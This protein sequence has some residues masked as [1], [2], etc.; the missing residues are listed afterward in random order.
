MVAVSLRF[1]SAASMVALLSTV[2]VFAQSQSGLEEII[3]TAQRRE[4]NLQDVPI[5]VT[6][7]SGEYLTEN[8]I[9]S[10]QDLAGAVPGLVVTN[11]LNYGTAPI[12]IRGIGAPNGGG[13]A[14]SDQPVAI[15]VD[16]VYVARLGTSVS[17][18]VDM[19]SIQVLRG[20]QGT[21]YG[22]NSTAG[23]LLL[24]SK[25]PTDQF[26][27]EFR[28]SYA[29]YNQSRLSAA[30]SGPLGSDRILGRLALGYS[31]GGD[32]VDNVLDGRELGGA[33]NKTARGTLRFLPSGGL[34]V[35]LIGEYQEQVAH[36]ALFSVAPLNVVTT[37]TFPFAGPLYEG[38]P[39]ARRADLDSTIEDNRVALDTD[40]FTE[41]RSSNGT[42]LVDWD[43]G[44]ITLAAISGYR[45]MDNNGQQDS[46]AQP[47]TVSYASAN[48]GL[49]LLSN[50]GEQEH[51]QY[52]QELRLQSDQGPLTWVAGAYFLHEENDVDFSIESFQAGPPQPGV[53]PQRPA[54]TIANFLSH[55]DL[56][57]YAAFFDVTWAF[58]D[59]WS[60]SVGGRYS[61]ESRQVSVRQSVRNRVTGANLTTPLAFS[62]EDSWTDF[63]PR[64]VLQYK[65]TDDTLVYANY[66]RGF[67]SGGYNSFDASPAATAFPQEEIDAYEIGL[68]SDLL[69]RRLRMNV[70]AFSYD[71][72]NVQI[73][74]AVFT[75]GVSIRTVPEARI[76]G[77]EIETTFTPVESLVMRANLSYL[78]AELRRGTLQALPSDI[79][80]V[81]YGAQLFA[82]PAVFPSE[83]VAGNRMT[84]APEWQY[85]LSG[86][87][88]WS[89]PSHAIRLSATWR[90]QT[91]VLFSETNQDTAGFIGEAWD[92]VDLRLALSDAAERWE[93]ALF[94][95][96][97][98]DDRH[99]TQIAPF[100]GFPV[101][102]ANMPA[103]YGV[104]AV[105]RT[106]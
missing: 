56:D 17:D 31:D 73:R 1:R 2:Q 86:D 14:F 44:A 58:T 102:S 21:L 61:D 72:Q 46:D 67:K 38:D 50:F 40:T 42:L 35:D 34:T 79:G 93:I 26:E 78:D 22:R 91:E 106:R 25:R 76:R 82:P 12:S 65:F 32:Y 92:E 66:S 75:G 33:R 7:V 96:N 37:P 64:G 4:Q 43:L 85:Y 41:L 28:G 57:A 80:T 8:N 101:A 13:G 16:G 10:L 9:S 69:D 103:Q 23:A 94:G 51:T 100:A 47:N 39:F 48:G 98:L 59:Q 11:T 90:G 99:L 77:V 3:V 83:D 71:Y 62:G 95:R 68:K 24:A 60:A 52:S 5:A 29:Q 84:R 30:L 53:P 20:P 54:G 87:Y 18:L 36:P 105:Y 74:Q 81:R 104:Q 27:S 63:S 19:D 45:I 49:R 15:Y 55:Q 89:L 70:S 97:V 6:A 88:T